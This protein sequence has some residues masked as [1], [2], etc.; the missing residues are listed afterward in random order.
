MVNERVETANG[1]V[2]RDIQ[3]S[4]YSSIDSRRCPAIVRLVFK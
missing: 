2:Q 4:L 3:L 1:P